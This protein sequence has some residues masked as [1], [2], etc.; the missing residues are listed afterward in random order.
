MRRRDPA[1]R[2]P[3]LAA[4]ARAAARRRREPPRPPAAR[5]APATARRRRCC[6]RRA[7][8]SPASRRVRRARSQREVGKHPAVY[9]EFVT[10]GQSIHWAFNDAAAAHARLMLHISTTMGYGAPAEITPRGHRPGRRRRATCCRLSA[11]IAH[12]GKPGLHPPAAGD[13]PGQQRL[14]RLQ[15]RRL[16]A[17]P[18]LRA[19]RVHRRLAARRDRAARRHAS[20]TID[21]QP[22]A[23]GQPPLHGHRRRRRRSPRRRSRSSGR[24]RSPARPTSRPTAP[25]PTTR[26][27]AYVDWVGTD[28]YSKFP[29]FAGLDAFY[30]RVPGQA[31]RVRRV[32]D[33][34]RRRPGLRRAVLRVGQRAPARADDA[35]QPGLRDQRPVPLNLDPDRRAIRVRR[36]RAPRFPPVSAR[37]SCAACAGKARRCEV[38]L[39][40]LA[41]GRSSCSS[42]RDGHR[43]RQ[44]GL[45]RDPRV[46]SIVS[47][48]TDE[49]AARRPSCGAGSARVHLVCVYETAGGRRTA[50]PAAAGRATREASTRRSPGPRRCSPRPASRS[51]C[52]RS[53]AIRPTR[54]STSPRS[55]T[56][57]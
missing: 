41:A 5:G 48:P 15:R 45:S 36:D 51:T 46:S 9:G 33:L 31:V 27:T 16:L 52:T 6:R 2:R 57:T 23:L 53:A 25:P 26:A 11:L 1:P 19:E 38:S 35:L 18:G 4:A 30:K 37:R 14:L 44:A 42:R 10:W 7:R 34:G 20:A 28:F 55:A 50:R 8:S 24:R 40:D 43:D 39:V 54:S 21:A 47:A 17:R 49:A 13:G 22:A 12:Y 32:G 3:V 56:P 29:N